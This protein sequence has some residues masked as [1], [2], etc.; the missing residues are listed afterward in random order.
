MLEEEGEEV[1]E[2]NFTILY[3]TETGNSQDVAERIARQARRRRIDTSVYA[4]DDYNVVSISSH[5][6]YHHPPRSGFSTDFDAV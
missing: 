6:Q 2:R 5:H 1:T 4:M 3:G